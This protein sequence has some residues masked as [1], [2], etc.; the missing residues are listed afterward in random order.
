MGDQEKIKV[1]L[2]QIYLLM[3]LT[4]IINIIN[5]FIILNKLFS[6]LDLN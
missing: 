2:K 6:L 4:I 3:F 1:A 5:L